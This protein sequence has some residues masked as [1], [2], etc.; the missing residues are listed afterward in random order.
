VRRETE[1][2]GGAAVEPEEATDDPVAAD[3]RNVYELEL[4]TRDAASNGR[5]IESDN[6]R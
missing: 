4:W 5:A 3:I 1:R 6:N 2:I